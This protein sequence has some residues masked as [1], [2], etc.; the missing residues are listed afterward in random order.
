MG[1]WLAFPAKAAF[2]F[3]AAS[4]K[5]QWTK[6]HAGD[7]EPLPD[8]PELLAAWAL[9]HNGQFEEA[10][11]AGLHMGGA[12]ITLANKSACM[13]AALLEARTSER[14]ALFQAVAERAEDQIQREPDNPNAHYHLAYALGFYSQGI[15]VAMAMAQGLGSKVKAAL[16]TTIGLQAQHADAHFRM[17]A[18][19]ADIIDKVGEMIALMTY[20]ARRDVSLQMFAQGFA[21]RPQCPVGLME[22][23]TA[24]RILEGDARQHEANALYAR[25]AA[26][27]PL[28]APEYL[29][30][31]LARLGLEA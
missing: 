27:Q 25:A 2:G 6:L 4:V 17:G 14:L 13:Y 22:Y 19:H 20:G 31:A 15:S 11:H 12:G 1:R 23:A 24:L 16:E 18:F 9:F 28:D 30:I 5:K 29:E 8:T 3:D 7:R 10:H 21:L 26:L